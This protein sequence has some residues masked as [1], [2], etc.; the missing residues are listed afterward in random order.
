[1]INP[2]QLKT[3]IHYIFAHNVTQRTA[4]FSLKGFKFCFPNATVDNLRH[5]A[6]QFG[7]WKPHCGPCLKIKKIGAGRIKFCEAI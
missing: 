1:M 4:Y 2:Q 3:T 5:A 6:C 7:D